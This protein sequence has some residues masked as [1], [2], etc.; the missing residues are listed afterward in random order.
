VVFLEIYFSIFSEHFLIKNGEL[1]RECERRKLMIMSS[2]KRQQK[3]VILISEFVLPN[4]VGF[5]LDASL[6]FSMSAIIVAYHVWKTW[7]G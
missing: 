5:I 3:I 1:K 6:G 2:Q 4:L 7:D